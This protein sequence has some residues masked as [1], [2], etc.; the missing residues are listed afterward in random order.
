MPPRPVNLVLGDVTLVAVLGPDQEHHHARRAD[1]RGGDGE[2]LVVERG[3]LGGPEEG[4][5]HG[6][7]V[8]C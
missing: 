4:T 2:T 7:E 1:E 6:G 3:V 5:V 8:T